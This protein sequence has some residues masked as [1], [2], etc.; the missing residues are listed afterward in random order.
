[1]DIGNKITLSIIKW[2]WLVP[3]STGQ[4]IGKKLLRLKTTDKDGKSIDVKTAV[5]ESFGEVQDGY[6]LTIKDRE[7][8]TG[9][10]AQ[11]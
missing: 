8:L 10:V 2:L 5:I 1:V 9:Q 7:Y 4:S 11:L 6:S 3:S